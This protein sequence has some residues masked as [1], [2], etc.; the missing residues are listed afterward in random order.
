M[1]RTASRFSFRKVRGLAVLAAL[2][3]SI[4]P[5]HA[6][7]RPAAAAT[8]DVTKIEGREYVS[9]D[10]IKRFYGFD[11]LV[12]SGDAIVLENAK[13]KINFRVGGTECLMNNVKFIFSNSVA[14]LGDK[15]YVSSVDF[16]KLVDPVLRP[17]FIKNAG[18]FRTVVLDPGHGGKDAG[19]TNPLGCES[20]YTLKIANAVKKLLVAKGYKVVMTRDSDVYISLQERVDIAN[21]VQGEAIFVSIHF[22]N[23]DGRSARGIETFTLSPP[24]V[25]HYGRDFRPDDNQSRAGNEHDSAN[26]ALATSVHGT[27]LRRLGTNTFDRG[28]K[29]ARFSVLSGVKHPAILFEGGFLSHPF[30]ARLIESEA[31]QTRLSTGIADAIERYRVAVDPEL[32]KAAAARAAAVKVSGKAN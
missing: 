28:I 19:C 24:G 3:M 11:K 6:Q 14:T 8:L 10:S 23:S 16:A 1:V 25:S 12:R 30:E 4:V 31:Y 17:N 27:I 26:I 7:T 22:N 5:A 13:V 29:R 9:I 15:F 32:A 18:D 20:N 21:A 2:A